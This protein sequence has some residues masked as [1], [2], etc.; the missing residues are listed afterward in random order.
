MPPAKSLNIEPASIDPGMP[1]N[2]NKKGSYVHIRSWLQM[3]RS[4]LLEGDAS[5]LEW[6]DAQQ[7]Q[8][9][10]P[11]VGCQNEHG[12]GLL[13]IAVRQQRWKS[14][15]WLVSMGC[16]VHQKNNHGHTPVW[17]SR[18]S[19][20]SSLPALFSAAVGTG[21]ITGSQA[22][23]REGG[24]IDSQVL[25]SKDFDGKEVAVADMKCEDPAANAIIQAIMDQDEISFSR[26]VIQAED[27]N[28][29][30]SD[31][32]TPLAFAIQK[33]DW[34][35]CIRLLD[36][37]AS[38]EVVDKGQVLW[39]RLRGYRK[40]IQDESEDAWA[41]FDAWISEAGQS[42]GLMSVHSTETAG[43][44]KSH[45]PKKKRNDGKKR[46]ASAWTGNT[47]S[48]H[49]A[50]RR[51]NGLAI[52][53]PEPR[54]EYEVSARSASPRPVVIVRRQRKVLPGSL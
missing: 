25:A 39:E 24:L 51:N 29:P 7:N 52:S 37:G 43:S 10:V 45:H 26:W 13:H 28:R 48:P 12:D 49:H 11:W 2:E 15:D 31:G 1:E 9:G 34:D 23:G 36:Y 35:R 42:D 14:A 6:V 33:K 21:D 46:T 47:V 8:G 4:C 27:L 53:L 44:K 19:K 18:K 41:V 38:L 5:F 16:D 3:A 40:E 32:Q 30:G 22:T 54:E 50:N 20:P 17:L